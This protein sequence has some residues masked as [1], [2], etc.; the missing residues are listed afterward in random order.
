MSDGRRRYDENETAQERLTR[1]QS[2][3]P[4]FSKTET[5]PGDFRPS[6]TSV[7]GSPI[8]GE[9]ADTELTRMMGLLAGLN[10]PRSPIGMDSP[11]AKSL[12][13]QIMA[14]SQAQSG[15]FMGMSRPGAEKPQ[16][17]IISRGGGSAGGSGGG[18]GFGGLGAL[19][20]MRMQSQQ[21]DPY[22]ELRKLMM[23]RAKEYLSIKKPYLY[24][25]LD[26]QR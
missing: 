22:A 8:G 18:G 13:A 20:Q 19:M 21:Q 9:D 10:A 3:N 24:S 7:Y 5:R 26:K 17:Q 23:E 11:Y 16:G 6:T 14:R 15:P 1:M 2:M 12:D 4:S 25:T